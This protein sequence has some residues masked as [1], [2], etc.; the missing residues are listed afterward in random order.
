[1]PLFLEGGNISESKLS[2]KIH[3]S[4]TKLKC[5]HPDSARETMT[6]FNYPSLRFEANDYTTNK[7]TATNT[8][9]NLLDWN[10]GKMSRID[11]ASVKPEVASSKAMN[12]RALASSK[13]ETRV[14]PY[15]RN[16]SHW[17]CVGMDQDGFGIVNQASIGTSEMDQSMESN[18]GQK[19]DLEWYQMFEMMERA[20]L[21]DFVVNSSLK[22][23]RA[24][25]GPLVRS[26]ATPNLINQSETVRNCSTS[27]LHPFKDNTQSYKPI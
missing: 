12:D 14:G 17:S 2:T 26:R 15:I 18:D 5:F 20:E 6:W 22:F 4:K 10:F 27:C 21:S 25:S 23:E 13:N 11:V 9:N 8:T 24:P 19:M 7:L 16:G 3:K 1:M